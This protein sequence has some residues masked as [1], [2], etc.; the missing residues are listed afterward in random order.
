MKNSIESNNRINK[1]SILIVL[2]III[3]LFL[4][5]KFTSINIAIATKVEETIIYPK[6][7]ELKEIIDRGFFLLRN[8]YDNKEM[9]DIVGAYVD[10]LENM[11]GYPDE[12]YVKYAKV[13]QHYIYNTKYGWIPY[14]MPQ[15]EVFY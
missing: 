14:K 1:K 5:L 7:K 10:L 4:S 8:G 12:K 2:L 9:R 15:I 11:L 3:T 13:K 6:D